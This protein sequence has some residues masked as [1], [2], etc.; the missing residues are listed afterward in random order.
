M[1][2]GRIT[3]IASGRKTLVKTDKP[4]IHN[5]RERKLNHREVEFELNSEGKKMT[6]IV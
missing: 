3:L 5:K 6:S 1:Q 4:Q 2:K